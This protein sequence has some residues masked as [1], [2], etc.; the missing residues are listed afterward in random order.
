MYLFDPTKDVGYGPPG[1]VHHFVH[2]L[3]DNF[4]Q[5]VWIL[6]QVVTG[7]RSF[8]LAKTVT[9]RHRCAKAEHLD[10]RL[11]CGRKERA[12]AA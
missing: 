4:K 7:S 1:S 5:N 2:L 6:H 11:Y 12:L 3:Q 10:F 8:E 9:K